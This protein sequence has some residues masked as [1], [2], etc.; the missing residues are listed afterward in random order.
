MK[1]KDL[2]ESI[3]KKLAELG[4]EFLEY[5]VYTEQCD[6]LDK[7]NKRGPQNWDILHVE[8]IVDQQELF[9]CAGFTYIWLEKK[10]FIIDVNY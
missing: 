1:V 8:D 2:T 10:A 7:E 6:E 9:K 5:D 3:A 4:P